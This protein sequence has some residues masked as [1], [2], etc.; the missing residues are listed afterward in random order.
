M[1]AITRVLC[2]CKGNG[3]RSPMMAGVLQMYLDRTDFPDRN[4][5]CESAGIPEIASNIVGASHH[6]IEAANRL[7]ID[8]GSHERRWVNSLDINEYHLIVCVDD[9]VAAHVIGLGA[10]I[11]NVY[12]AQI[13]NPWPSQFQRD[14]DD[15]AEQIMAKMYRVVT[16]HF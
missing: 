10:D 5:V 8:L 6:M 14:F 16:R 3:D 9:K 4:V 15:T 12:N 11:S 2:V 7:N 13:S 1:D